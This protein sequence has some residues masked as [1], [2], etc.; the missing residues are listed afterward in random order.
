MSSPH[1]QRSP[2]LSSPG[3]RPSTMP[4]ESVIVL[5]DNLGHGGPAVPRG[6]QP[7]APTAATTRGS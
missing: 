4:R 2:T 5:R 1:R 6:G 7:A 3:S